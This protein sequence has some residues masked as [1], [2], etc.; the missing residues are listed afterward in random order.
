MAAELATY[1]GRTI[2]AVKGTVIVAGK[3]FKTL[4][5]ATHWLDRQS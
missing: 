5:Q 1:K 4:E 3:K 2:K